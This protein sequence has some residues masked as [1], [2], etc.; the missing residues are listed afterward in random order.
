LAII[1]E[2][3]PEM[4]KK[5]FAWVKT[6][7]DD[8]FSKLREHLGLPKKV[9]PPPSATKAA[10]TAA[11]DVARKVDDRPSLIEIFRRGGKVNKI[12]SVSL[13]R[14]RNVLGRAGVS[15]SNYKLQKATK[16]EIEALIK[17]GDDVE[18]I[19][20]WVSR[21]GAGKL[22]TDS[23]GRPII[24]FTKKGLSSLEEAVKTFGH[25][26]KHIQDFLAGVQSSSEALAELAG[27]KLWLLVSESLKK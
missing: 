3:T 13:K 17:R 15:P 25:E 18:S 12:K 10:E 6:Q 8:V 16:E 7:I 1:R 22:I 9:E 20:A 2:K 11:A 14:L 26:V 19:F 23:K 5:A 21:D 24:T 4:L 27:E